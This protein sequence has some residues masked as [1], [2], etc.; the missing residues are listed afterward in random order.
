MGE[1]WILSMIAGQALDPTNFISPI[2]QTRILYYSLF[3]RKK[4]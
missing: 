2:F 4:M 1:K 3:Y